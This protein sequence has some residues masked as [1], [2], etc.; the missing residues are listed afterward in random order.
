LGA[1]ELSCLQAEAKR[2]S[3]EVHINAERPWAP[4]VFGLV[5]E[6]LKPLA[7]ALG[8]ESES[9]LQPNINKAPACWPQENR[10]GVGYQCIATWKLDPGLFDRQESQQKGK[11]TLDRMVHEK[12]RDLFVIKGGENTFKTTQR[13]VA[14]MEYA[15]LTKTSLFIKD[16]TMLVR[17]GCGGHLPINVAIWLRRL[18]G[19]QTGLDFTRGRQTYLYGG[20]EAAIEIM[21]R[22]F[23]MAIQSPKNTSISVAVRHLAAQRRRGLRPNYYQ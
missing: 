23:G 4:P 21:Q 7:E 2:L 1:S 5:G 18:T 16:R 3:V 13:V 6:A 9:A 22:A 20:T 12:D 19:V 15:R 14:L 11:I 10:E 8:W 17:N